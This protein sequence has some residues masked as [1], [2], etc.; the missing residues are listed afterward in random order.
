MCYGTE[1]ETP[2]GSRQTITV[3]WP[4][5]GD[6]KDLTTTFEILVAPGYTPGGGSTVEN[7]HGGGGGSF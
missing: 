6:G 5:P 1:T 7:G 4:R 2:A 3:T